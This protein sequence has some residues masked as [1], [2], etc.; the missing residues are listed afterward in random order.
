MQP[1]VMTTMNENEQ[2][3]LIRMIT[4]KY[5]SLQDLRFENSLNSWRQP[6]CVHST[7]SQYLS[8]MSRNLSAMSMNLSTISQ[9]LSAMPQNL[10]V[11][12]QNLSAIHQHLSAMPQNV[13]TVFQD[14][15]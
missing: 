15:L 6:C 11:M 4:V 8:I 14:M 2:L 12:P 5:I 3:N 10:S 1:F 9:N 13:S 7:M